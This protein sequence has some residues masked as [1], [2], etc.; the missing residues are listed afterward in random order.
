MIAAPPAPA[1]DSRSVVLRHP[2]A[3]AATYTE[4]AGSCTLALTTQN[5]PVL[6]ATLDNGSNVCLL[7]LLAQGHARRPCAS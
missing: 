1:F 2:K 5:T 7:V 3:Q 4:T 6:V